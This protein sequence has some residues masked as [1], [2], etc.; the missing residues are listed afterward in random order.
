MSDFSHYAA[1][2][3]DNKLTQKFCF[4]DLEGKPVLEVRAATRHNKAYY[5]LY[6][7][8]VPKL[9]R[10]AVAGDVNAEEEARSKMA[11]IYARTV[12]VGWPTP[13]LDSKGKP[14]KFS[15]DACQDF[16][17]QI[18]DYMFSDIAGEYLAFTQFVQNGLNFVNAKGESLA[19]SGPDEEDVEEQAKN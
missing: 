7:E 11:S 2:G 6:Q 17:E 8:A 1:R 14:V 12:V 10:L 16:L 19:D 5:K 9:R 3:V 4:H 15:Q 18:P 13:P